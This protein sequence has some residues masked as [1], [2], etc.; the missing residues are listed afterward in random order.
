MYSKIC[1]ID[2]NFTHCR[3]MSVDIPTVEEELTGMV[4]EMK[5]DRLNSVAIWECYRNMSATGTAICMEY[6]T[7]GV[8]INKVTI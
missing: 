5:L 7:R 2:L 4:A 6:L 3:D 1:P 8:I